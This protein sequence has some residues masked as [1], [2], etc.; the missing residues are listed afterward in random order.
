MTELQAKLMIFG[1]LIILLICLYLFLWHVYNTKGVS[2]LNRWADRNGYILLKKEIR[3]FFRGPFIMNS[4]YIQCVFEVEVINQEKQRRHGWV[5]C[6]TLI[7]GLNSDVAVVR[8]SEQSKA[9][10]PNWDRDLE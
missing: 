10:S 3:W 4:H 7:S 2:V 6:G 5:R 8:W 1:F 9:D